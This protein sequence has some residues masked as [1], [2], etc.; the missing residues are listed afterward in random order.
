MYVGILLWF[1]NK[2][3]RS[4]TDAF[5]LFFTLLKCLIVEDMWKNLLIIIIFVW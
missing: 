4:T 2:I 1:E 3:S 5:Y